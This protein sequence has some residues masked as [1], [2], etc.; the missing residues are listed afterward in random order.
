DVAGSDLAFGEDRADCVLDAIGR[1]LFSEIAQ[2]QY[3]TENYGGGISDSFTGD[4]GG[5]A[6][7]GLENGNAI[8]DV[9][10]WR[11][12]E[13][14]DETGGQIRHNVA[15]QVLHNHDVERMRVQHE[16]HRGGV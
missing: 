8:P 3:S 14:T 12:T 10:A 1:C 2:H 11:E 13:T 4:V 15:K 16:F 6:V 5:G 7:H 9:R